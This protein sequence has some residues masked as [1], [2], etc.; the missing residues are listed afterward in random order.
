MSRFVIVE[1]S[2]DAKD[3]RP[4]GV[5]GR[6][7]TLD[8]PYGESDIATFHSPD[9]ARAAAELAPNRREG[10]ELWVNG[11]KAKVPA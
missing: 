5:S 10:C 11:Q 8:H 1:F 7:L 3:N 9:A 4:L 2:P 6:F